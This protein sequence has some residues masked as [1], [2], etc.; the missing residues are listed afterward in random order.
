MNGLL[1]LQCTRSDVSVGS[2]YLRTPCLVSQEPADCTKWK[3][4]V[5]SDGK[6]RWEG[7]RDE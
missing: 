5:I 4:K 2:D 6:F 1:D 3:E 7:D